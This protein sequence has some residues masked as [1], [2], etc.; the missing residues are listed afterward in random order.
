MRIIT[1]SSITRS[2]KAYP[3]A[4]NSLTVWE[5]R[6]RNQNYLNSNEL[7]ESFGNTDHIPNSNFS[8]LTIFNIKGNDYRLAVDIDFATQRVFL[9]W[10]ATHAKYDRINWNNYQN[11][12]FELC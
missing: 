5:E 1:P 7:R 10:F 8:H 6:I 3:S 2:W 4:K 9:K 12:G 11:N